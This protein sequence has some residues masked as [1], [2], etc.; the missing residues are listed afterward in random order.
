MMI[1]LK[2]NEENFRNYNEYF[3]YV[4]YSIFHIIRGPRHMKWILWYT[5]DIMVTE[6]SVEKH[7]LFY[8]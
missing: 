6:C 5:K 8:T 2:I 4:L 3:L 1:Y 7:P